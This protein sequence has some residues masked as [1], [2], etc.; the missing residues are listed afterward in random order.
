MQVAKKFGAPAATWRL[1]VACIHPLMTSSW[2]PLVLAD[3]LRPCQAHLGGTVMDDVRSS[4]AIYAL[5]RLTIDTARPVVFR[6]SRANEDIKATAA[7]ASS[8][9]MGARA[10]ADVLRCFNDMVAGHLAT[11]MLRMQ[12]FQALQGRG[13]VEWVMRA[14]VQLRS[15]RGCGRWSR[16][17]AKRATDDICNAPDPLERETLVSMIM[18]WVGSDARFRGRLRRLSDALA[19]TDA[20]DW[21]ALMSELLKE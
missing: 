11:C 12:H 10:V 20:P 15:L 7:W 9:G 3:Y 8:T 17:A 1:S 21:G 19:A 13:Y 4:D 6:G 2:R 5:A 16:A 18:M 14:C